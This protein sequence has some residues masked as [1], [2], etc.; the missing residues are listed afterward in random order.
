MNRGARGSAVWGAKLGS[1][2]SPRCGKRAQGEN[3]GTAGRMILQGSPGTLPIPAA[4][5]G[6]FTRA[7]TLFSDTRSDPPGVHLPF[8]RSLGM[9]EEPLFGFHWLFL[10]RRLPVSGRYVDEFFTLVF[11]ERI[12]GC[13]DWVCQSEGNRLRLSLPLNCR[14]STQS[15]T[16]SNELA[17][18]SRAG[19]APVRN[20]S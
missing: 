19:R 11:G 12:R 9:S 1:D 6:S 16:R 3:R 20:R 8:H 2:G 15:I 18:R 14:F 10:D 7:S 13:G 17:C 5:A 4:V